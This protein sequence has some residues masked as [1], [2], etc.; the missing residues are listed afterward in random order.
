MTRMCSTASHSWWRFASRRPCGAYK[1]QRLHQ[2]SIF[3]CRLWWR[4]IDARCALQWQSLLSE[5]VRTARVSD[6]NIA[7]SQCRV[8]VRVGCAYVCVLSSACVCVML[9]SRQTLGVQLVSSTAGDGEADLSRRTSGYISWHTCTSQTPC[10]HTFSMGSE[11]SVGR[12]S[13]RGRVRVRIPSRA[14][15]SRRPRYQRALQCDAL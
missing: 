3:E 1:Q 9:S 8:R 6:D 7:V 4:G 13:S 5:S 15:E 10:A 12:T 14:R 11:A 2:V